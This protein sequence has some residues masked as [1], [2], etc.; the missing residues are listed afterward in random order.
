MDRELSYKTI[1]EIHETQSRLLAAQ[2]GMG[3]EIL[4]I[5]PGASGRL[6]M[7]HPSPRWMI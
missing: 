4:A 2:I 1:S 6:I 7:L 3:N 5:L